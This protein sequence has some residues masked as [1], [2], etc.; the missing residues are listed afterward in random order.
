F[1]LLFRPLRTSVGSKYVMALTGIGLLGFVIVHM[2]GN[3]LIYLGPDALN[4]YA[5]ALKSNPELLWSARTGLLLIFVIHLI[6]SIRLTLQNKRARGVSYTYEDTVQASWA[7]RHM[8]L[9]GLV[10]LAF[11]VFHLA[12]FTLGIVTTYTD[13]VSDKQINYLDL[14]DAKDPARHD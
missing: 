1:L 5:K 3:L 10:L 14:H 11:I 7:S 12:H 6:L 2:L 13:P 9:T 4:S 8:L